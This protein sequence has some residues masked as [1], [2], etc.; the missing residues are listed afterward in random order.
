MSRKIR[1][2][3]K[4]S[5][6]QEGNIAQSEFSTF[7]TLDYSP[8]CFIISYH[9]QDPALKGC[10]SEIKVTNSSVVE[11]KRIGEFST[12]LTLEKGRR[13]ICLYHT[14]FGEI[15]MGVFARKVESDMSENG[16]TLSLCYTLDF[17]SGLASVN[18]LTII[19]QEA[20][21]DVITG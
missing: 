5:H 8:D 7:G 16:G 13:H 9:E 2:T 12:Q 15:N 19:A 11:L 17:N 14:P 6:T 20:D 3:I 21:D 4:D 10:I 18:E 1:I